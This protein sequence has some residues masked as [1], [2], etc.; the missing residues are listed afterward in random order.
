VKTSLWQTFHPDKPTVEAF[1]SGWPW[2]KCEEGQLQNLL[3]LHRF[4]FKVS[5][6]TGAEF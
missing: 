6:K 1:R 4:N 5:R 2:G 3:V